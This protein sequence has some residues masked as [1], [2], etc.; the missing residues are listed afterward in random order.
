MQY[1]GSTQQLERASA[2]A[3]CGMIG[4]QLHPQA[5][6][7]R[8]QMELEKWI[9]RWQKGERDAGAAA[10]SLLTAQGADQPRRHATHTWF[11]P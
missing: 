4:L 3:V 6:G 9:I 2:R 10:G 1:S 8:V 7:Q 5:L 11:L